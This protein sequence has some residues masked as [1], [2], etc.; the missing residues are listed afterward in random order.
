MAMAELLSTTVRIG[1]PQRTRRVREWS[2]EEVAADAIS[3]LVVKIRGP[4]GS[5]KMDSPRALAVRPTSGAS[6]TR[7]I[8]SHKRPLSSERF[9]ARLAQHPLD[10]PAIERVVLKSGASANAS[11]P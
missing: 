6:S 7:K 4:V 9:I 11:V 8:S 5:V 1:I 3:D 2:A 10:A